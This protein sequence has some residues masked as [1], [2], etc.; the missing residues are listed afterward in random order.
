MR[1]RS[2]SVQKHELWGHPG[3]WLK[4][5]VHFMSMLRKRAQNMKITNIATSPPVARINHFKNI[6]G[7]RGIHSS[8]S[9]FGSGKKTSEKSPRE[10]LQGRCFP[11]LNSSIRVCAS[12][13]A[14]SRSCDRVQLFAMRNPKP[15]V[16]V[17]YIHI[18]FTNSRAQCKE[19][20]LQ[21]VN[22]LTVHISSSLGCINLTKLTTPGHK[23]LVDST[24]RM[25]WSPVH[26]VTVL[27]R[28]IIQ[29]VNQST[30]QRMIITGK[31]A[32]VT[33]QE[34]VKV[35]VRTPMQSFQL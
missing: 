27:R 20:S 25:L 22:N 9:T 16:N 32:T 7:L 13:D 8:S 3:P 2:Q 14:V 31:S 29:R 26:L 28:V 18:G 6:K 34:D 4:F 5:T 17:S 19:F 15:P 12:L 33:G 30:C 1:R 23:R 35:R 21:V 24:H 10:L 11:W